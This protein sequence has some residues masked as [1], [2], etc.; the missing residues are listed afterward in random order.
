MP[1]NKSTGDKRQ[2]KRI[3]KNI[4][5]E[6]AAES[7]IALVHRKQGGPASGADYKLVVKNANFS[8][9][10]MEK[11][12]KIKV[13]MDIVEYL[14]RFYNV[15]GEN[16]EVLAR[17]LGFTTKR[18]EKYALEQQ[19]QMLEDQEEMIDPERPDYDSDEKEWE[20]YIT[21]RVGSLE[22]MKSLY[23]AESIPAALAELDEDEYLM[24]LTDQEMLEKAFAEVERLN[25]ESKSTTGK[26]AS[27]EEH[28]ETAVAVSKSD[29]EASASGKKSKRKGLEKPMTKEV[30][31]QVEV[32]TKAQFESLTKAFDEQTVEL[33][34]ALEVIKAFEQEKKE[35]ILK[36]RK[37]QLV[38]AVKDEEKAEVVFKA[39]KDSADE[40]FE[41]VVKAL[42]DIQVAVEKSGLFE[43]QGASAQEDDGVQESAV[44]KI[45]KAKQ[46][47]AK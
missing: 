29:G 34:K 43:E 13:E 30:E 46:A 31:D 5:F 20:D 26:D 35:A 45:L 18:Q 15:Y 39:V 3:L 36:A 11:A 19:E 7:H 33:N 28:E 47:K 9:A 44:A 16:A 8:D 14:E 21:S 6:S 32:V 4:N 42:K 41:A 1:T 23:E 25:K 10:F 2:A 12:S 40:D 37:A 38:D 27:N 17:A 24:L 22:V